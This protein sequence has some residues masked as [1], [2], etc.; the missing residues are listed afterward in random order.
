MKKILGN[1]QDIPTRHWFSEFN[2]FMNHRQVPLMIK[3][4]KL[5]CFLWSFDPWGIWIVLYISALDLTAWH[6]DNFP[7]NS[8]YLNDDLQNDPRL[9]CVRWICPLKDSKGDLLRLKIPRSNHI[10]P[11]KFTEPYEGTNG[12]FVYIYMK[13]W[14]TNIHPVPKKHNWT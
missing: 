11:G 1:S 14:G 13:I 12:N 4:S 3:S 6:N 10:H 7:K 5:Y 8:A 9:F 2:R